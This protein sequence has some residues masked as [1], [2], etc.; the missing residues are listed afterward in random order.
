MLHDQN[1]EQPTY[2]KTKREAARHLGVSQGSLERLMRS[3]LVY[4]RVG[5]LV[6]FRPEDLADYIEQ[7]RVQRSGD[8]A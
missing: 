5:N 3:G 6:R 4:I 8:A 2:L 7:R 1:V